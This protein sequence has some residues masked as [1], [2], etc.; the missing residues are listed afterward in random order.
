[1]KFRE[2]VSEKPKS[3]MY[4]FLIL[5]CVLLASYKVGVQH[6]ATLTSQDKQGDGLISPHSVPSE[7]LVRQGEEG[8]RSY[9]W[10]FLT[11]L[12]LSLRK[13]LESVVFVLKYSK[14]QKKKCVCVCVCVCVGR[15]Q[16]DETRLTGFL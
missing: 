8:S 11:H 12:F 4:V 10:S 14:K 3:G 5:Q 15:G 9:L 13:N 16:I 1:M 6:A 2:P 7:G